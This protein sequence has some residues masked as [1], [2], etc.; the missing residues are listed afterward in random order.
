MAQKSKEK[1][2]T[3]RS[4]EYQS[5]GGAVIDCSVV[6]DHRESNASA[7]VMVRSSRNGPTIPCERKMEWPD[8]SEKMVYRDLPP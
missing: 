2:G 6:N 8:S 4:K 5:P 3:E 1:N 7:P